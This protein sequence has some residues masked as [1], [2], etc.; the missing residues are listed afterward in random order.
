LRDKGLA[1]APP[2]DNRTLIRRLSFDLTGLPPDPALLDEPY[3]KAVERL[4]AS[5]RYGERWG[6]HWLDVVRFGE[7]DGGE[8]NFERFNSWPYRDYVIDAFNRDVPYNQFV[9]E[10]IAGDVLFPNDRARIAATGFLVS[11]PWD[12]VSAVLN[13]D[14]LMRK[15]ARMDELDDMVTTTCATFLGLTVNCARCHNHKFDPIPTRDY[16]RIAAAFAGAGIAQ[17]IRAQT[18]S[19]P[20]PRKVNYRFW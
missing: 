7:T 2:A 11:G 3:D 18:D 19:I 6:R 17:A 16:Y 10:Q 1:F 9:R 15:T 14:P 12:Q 5:P 13:K 4:L 8:H 20:Q